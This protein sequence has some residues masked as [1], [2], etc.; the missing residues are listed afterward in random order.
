MGAFTFGSALG[1]SSP[2]LI[3]LI[4]LSATSENQSRFLTA[5]VAS[6]VPLG[7]S[8]GISVWTYFNDKLGPRKSM[9]IQAPFTLLV[10]IFLGTKRSITCYMV[11]RFFCGFFSISYVISGETLLIESIH[12]KNLPCMIIGHRACILLGVLFSYTFTTLLRQII[13][14][15]TTFSS[16]NIAFIV[17]HF[18]MLCF[19]PESPVFLYNVNE[20]AA[21][22]SLIWYRG[23][24]ILMEELRIIK[25]DA[26]IKRTDPDADKYMFYSRVVIKALLII[27]ALYF[28]QVF[29]GYY[30][31][32]FQYSTIWEFHG[33]TFISTVV[34]SSIYGCCM[35]LSN[36]VGSVVHFRGSYGVRKPLLISCF[37]IFLTYTLA[38]IYGI[39]YNKNNQSLKKL[40]PIMPLIITCAYVICYE[41]GLSCYPD[42]LIC[43]YMPHQIYLRARM[44]CKSVNWFFVFLLMHVFT[45][46]RK[47]FH[48][49]VVLSASAALSLCAFIF[50]YF[51]VVE[52][53]NKNL[54][55]IQIE[56]GGNPVGSRGG[57]RQRNAGLDRTL[58]TAAV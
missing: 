5:W 12:R 43:D 1:W 7:S 16:S 21:I 22:K 46:T 35:L 15:H 4:D 54:I 53:R 9:M 8:I 52:T 57:Y 26:E 33:G 18:I 17:I 32:M 45:F 13:R 51:F 40:G 23:R 44:I 49:E 28:F 24:E 19:C 29:S 36:S 25:K 50:V 41:M 20:E 34:D 48:M 47:K 3:N 6:L 42:I 39:F 11:A 37:S 27:V 30:A 10:W 31:F 14:R 38:S 55:K 58:L 56:L 2:A